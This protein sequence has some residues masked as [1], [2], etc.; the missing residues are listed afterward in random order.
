[1]IRTLTLLL[2][3][4]TIA[5]TQQ[6]CFGPNTVEEGKATVEEENATVE[7]RNAI[8]EEENTIVE[9]E[10]ANFPYIDAPEQTITFSDCSIELN[11]KD[12]NGNDRIVYHFTAKLTGMEEHGVSMLLSVES[13]PGIP[14]TYVDGNGNVQYVRAEKTFKNKNKTDSFSLKNE[15]VEIQYS[16]LH[17]KKGENTYYVHLDA[18]DEITK[19]LI[20]GDAS[21]YISVSLTGDSGSDSNDSSTGSGPKN[22]AKVDYGP[23]DI[24]Q[25]ENVCHWIIPTDGKI[26]N[27][28]IIRMDNGI[29]G[30]SL[31]EDN[32]PEW[33]Y[34][35]AGDGSYY[36]CWATNR[37]FVM[38][39][40]NGSAFDGAKLQLNQR[41]GS[42]GQR[43]FFESCHTHPEYKKM[44]HE[45]YIL[46]TA[47]DTDYVMEMVEPS[48]VLKRYN[49]SINQKW[50]IR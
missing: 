7:E 50:V 4:A 44:D 2:L 18:Y 30:F 39:V 9:E 11:A 42:K 6:G 22:W 36:V 16:E 48:V 8:I 15:I 27:G 1:M 47:L 35:S 34:E 43:W 5:L 31:G 28:S 29:S 49:G 12:D 13:S 32:Y 38:E 3:V 46:H 21:P 45:G 25:A 33:V 41:N 10:N 14:H 37:N 19:S 26:A 17:L 24:A 40:Q 20:L 23:C